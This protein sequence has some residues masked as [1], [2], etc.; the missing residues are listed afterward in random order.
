MDRVKK[1]RY[2]IGFSLLLISFVWFFVPPAAS[3][4]LTR[5]LIPVLAVLGLIFIILGL[6]R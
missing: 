2:I 1:R 3:I 5:I 4:D 6:M